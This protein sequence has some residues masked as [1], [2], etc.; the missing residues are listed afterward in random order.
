[1]DFADVINA[2]IERF[3]DSHWIIRGLVFDPD[4]KGFSRQETDIDVL[5]V[6]FVNQQGDD[7]YGFNG[8]IYFPTTYPDGDGGKLYLHVTF[9]G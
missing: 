5:P 1:M 8:T 9:S 4:L 7:D 2:L 3:G 6:E